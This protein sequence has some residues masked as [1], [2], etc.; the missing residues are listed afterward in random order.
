MFF[1]K[2]LNVVLLWGH[3]IDATEEEGEMHKNGILI[4]ETQK[5]WIIVMLLFV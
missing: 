2:V 4:L 3:I 1:L 5:L